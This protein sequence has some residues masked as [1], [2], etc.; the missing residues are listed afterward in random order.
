MKCEFDGRSTKL[1]KRDTDHEASEEHFQERKF[2]G[3]RKS[4]VI[5]TSNDESDVQGSA[6]SDQTSDV[7][8][9]TETG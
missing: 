4:L 7:N 9:N 5:D 1:G 2:R 6:S 8:E 3:L